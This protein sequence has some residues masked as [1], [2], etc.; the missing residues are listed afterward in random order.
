MGNYIYIYNYESQV[1]KNDIYT[2]QCRHSVLIL[3]HITQ[4]L[5]K[6]WGKESM[7]DAIDIRLLNPRAFFISVQLLS[8]VRLFAT[9]WTFLEGC[10]QK[11]YKN[12]KRSL[13]IVLA[14]R[15][16]SPAFLN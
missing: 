4:V 6:D 13:E 9:P 15:M 12:G 2:W 5:W 1:N 8:R 11:I 10:K 7:Q 14:K 3:K 16:I